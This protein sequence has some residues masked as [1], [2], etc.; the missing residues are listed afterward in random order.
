MGLA[1]ALAGFLLLATG[2]TTVAVEATRIA[3]V[4]NLTGQVTIL[5]AGGRLPAKLGDPSFEKVV[6]ETGA[7]GG[8]GITSID[9]TYFRRA[10][11]ARS[12]STNSGSIRT[13]SRAKC[14]RICDRELWQSSLAISRAALLGR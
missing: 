14:W 3:Q 5:R 1:L 2:G 7:D 4:K 11:I 8:I 10:Q 12:R 13:T 9:N 6:V